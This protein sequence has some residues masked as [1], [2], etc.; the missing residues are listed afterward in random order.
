VVGRLSAQ[1]AHEVL[2]DAVARCL[3]DVPNLRVVL[4]GDGDRSAALRR[5]AAELGIT[6]RTTFMGIRRDVT[7]L[8]P[9]FDVS[10][11]S[12]VHEGVP[13]A[14]ME[15][16]A[17][18]VPIVASDCGSVRDIV[19]DGKEGFVVPV[20]DS[21][22]LAD[23]LRLLAGDDQ[24]RRRLGKSARSRAEREFSIEKTARGYEQL[25]AELAGDP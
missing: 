13:I 11:L 5:Y 22:L 9:G 21:H 7:E 8:L 20:R 1:K 19:T 6:S 10:C 12:S 15:A 25:L 4:I 3:P 14:L 17:A 2:L 24:L 18:S 16:M 23:R